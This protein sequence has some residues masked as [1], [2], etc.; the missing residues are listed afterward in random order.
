MTAPLFA[1]A[2]NSRRFFCLTND[3]SI[4]LVNA[5]SGRRSQITTRRVLCVGFSWDD[6]WTACYLAAEQ[7][8]RSR[9]LAVP[10]REAGPTPENEWVAVTTGEF[11]DAL[12]DFSPDGRVLYFMSLRDGFGCLWAQRLDPAT[13]K[14]KGRPFAV[15]HFHTARRSPGSVRP[16][17]RAISIARN[18]LVSTMDERTGNIWMAEL[19]R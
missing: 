11:S 12:P 8:G 2:H 17:Q 18:M 14:P 7:P 13:K 15:Q 10:I 6:Q 16:G 9:V 3:G 1:W 19:P 4:W 5:E